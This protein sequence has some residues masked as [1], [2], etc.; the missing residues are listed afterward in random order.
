MT[1]SL[2]TLLLFVGSLGC[3]AIAHHKVAGYGL[4]MPTAMR[5]LLCTTFGVCVFLGVWGS[6]TYALWL[7]GIPLTIGT[8]ER[9]IMGGQWWL[10]PFCLIWAGLAYVQLRHG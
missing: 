6:V 1:P 2:L 7:M 10:G 5:H 4:G 8:I 9:G 3:G